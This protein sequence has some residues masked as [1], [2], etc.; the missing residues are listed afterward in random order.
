MAAL[1]SG[2]VIAGRYRLD[3]RF[4]AG[5]RAQVWS[6]TDLELKR[7]VAVKVLVT[8]PD[9]GPG[10]LDAFRSEAQLE[11]SL[12]HPNIAEVL[13]WGQQGDLNYEVMELLPG[14]TVERLLANGPMAPHRVIELGRQAAGALAYA[15]SA[16]VAHGS[17]SPA[18][19]IL[20]PD[21]RTSLI[22]FGLQC[23]GSCEYP[24]EPDADTYALGIVMYEALTGASPVGPRPANVPENEPWPQR[25]HKLVEGVS[26]A[27]DHIVMKA[28]SPNPDERYRSAA[29]LKADLD[30]LVAPKNRTW[31]WVTLG[32]IAA[33]LLAGLIALAA[34]QIKV[35]VPDVVG[36]PQ[37]NALATL[38]AAGLKMVVIGQAPSPTLAQGDIV[39]ETPT[40]GARVRRGSQVGVTISTGKPTA[41]VPGVTGLSFSAA[42]SAL[43]SAGLSVGQVT[44]QNST[45]FP[46]ETVI[47]QSSPAGAQL[48]AG[49]A[50]NL[51][52]STGAKTVSVP[53]VRGMSEAN[54]TDKLQGV[55]LAVNVGSVFSGQPKGIVVSQGPAGGSVVPVGSTVSI[56]V[57][58][59]P[60]PV[61]VPNVVGAQQ[62]DAKNSLTGVGLVPVSVAASGTPGVVQSQSPA[63]GSKVAPGSQVKIFVG[64]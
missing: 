13:D 40:A 41:T 22:D 53:D 11:A 24:A 9:A 47:S 15:H 16:G 50:V 7:E 36:Q 30:A 31:L 61:T 19:V 52:V 23:R 42:S 46:T 37:A 45:T 44:Q 29:Q 6:A 3:N 51:V 39:S 54:A 4:D 8:P 26:S 10:F 57:S 58:K 5:G 62:S 49:T 12:K 18:H 38:S 21:G 2:S 34:T 60:A 55:G 48:P 1:E 64:H 27:F 56:S 33:L 25:P 20:G 35:T 14:E 59:G 17:V 32:V 43:T 28:V 63:A